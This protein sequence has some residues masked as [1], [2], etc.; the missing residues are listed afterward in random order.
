MLKL[1]TSKFEVS[2]QFKLQRSARVAGSVPPRVFS[3]AAH[4][5]EPQDR[6][7]QDV[8][9]VNEVARELLLPGLRHAGCAH[10]LRE[11]A[12]TL[13]SRRRSRRLHTLDTTTH[14][15]AAVL[16]SYR[17]LDYECLLGSLLKRGERLNMCSASAASRME[18]LEAQ[19]ALTEANGATRFPS[20]LRRLA[21][22]PL[23]EGPPASPP[24]VS[25]PSA[26]VCALTRT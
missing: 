4:A 19:E 23:V 22:F 16:R 18:P 20:L 12:V 6:H 25:A 9:R 3:S 21:V 24:P 1:Q 26:R 10:L 15:H 7:G 17:T 13:A 8:R 11:E 14:A 5:E 2:F